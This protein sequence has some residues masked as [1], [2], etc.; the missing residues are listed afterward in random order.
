MTKFWVGQTGSTI[1]Y[2]QT[3]S[4]VILNFDLEI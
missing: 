3:Q 4:A 1:A 2:S